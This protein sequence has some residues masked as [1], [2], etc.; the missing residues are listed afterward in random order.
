MNRVST[1]M[2]VCSLG[3]SSRLAGVMGAALGLTLALGASSAAYADMEPA[4]TIKSL[5]TCDATNV[6]T[7]KIGILAALSA[8]GLSAAGGVCG[9]G[10]RY[11]FQFAQAD[12]EAQRND[13]AVT[14]FRRLNAEE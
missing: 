9:T 5:T 3:A 12:A 1:C 8:A 4:P 10:V 13:A 14:G 7:A 2:D 6:K 11:K